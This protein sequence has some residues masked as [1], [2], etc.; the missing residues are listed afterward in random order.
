MTDTRV[1]ETHSAVVLLSGD[2]VLKWK[3]PLD[4]GFV[5][6]RTLEAREHACR[7]EVR[8]NSRLAP[9]V[10]QGVGQ[11]HGADGDVEEHVVL[12]RRLPDDARL[13]VRAQSGE[14]IDA[15][16]HDLARMLADFHAQCE[17]AADADAIAG[18]KRLREL[19][20]IGLSALAGHAPAI[21]DPEAVL[22]AQQLVTAYLDGREPLLQQRVAT[23]R[24]RDGHGDLLADDVFLLPD[25]PRVLDCLEFD[26]T[27]RHGDVLNDISMLLADLERLGAPEEAGTFLRAYQL[28]GGEQHPPSLRHL[29]VAYRAQVRAK[30]ACVRAEQTSS[31]AV[32]EEQRQLARQ[33]LRQVVDHLELGRVRLVLVGGLPGSGKSTL[34]ARVSGSIGATMLSSDEVRRSALGD[35]VDEN[36]YAADQVDLVYE[37][38]L[39][40]ART[41][42]GLGHSVVL[43]ASWSQQSHRRAAR[44]LASET[45]SQL[46][47]LRCTV[48]DA[49]ATARIGARPPH[50][51]S[52]ATAAVRGWMTE[53]YAAW[54]E[55]TTIDCAVPVDDS[56]DAALA[57]VSHPRDGGAERAPPPSGTPG[58]TPP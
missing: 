45:G 34:A 28:A 25:G 35:Q 55:A 43:D 44:Q 48:D 56:L 52:D 15:Q 4:L 32:R 16:L 19:W 58:A 2:R 17:P 29:Y 20:Q 9:D 12:M 14:D 47:E 31:T 11:L 1:I 8:L 42:L 27:L 57:A 5:D 3:K 18:P 53:R 13:S 30:V 37:L 22:H 6:Y 7:E 24:I 50:H 41:L 38:V 26:E 36:R 10:Y 49:T 21:V 39:A 46:R 40:Q 33:L 51:A 23:G 54:P